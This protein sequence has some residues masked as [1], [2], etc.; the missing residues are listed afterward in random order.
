MAARAAASGKITLTKDG[1]PVDKKN[2]KGTKWVYRNILSVTRFPLEL[3]ESFG[4]SVTF[5]LSFLL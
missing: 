3:K 1:F 5:V 2:S 4:F